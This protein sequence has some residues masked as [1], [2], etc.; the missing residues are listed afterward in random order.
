[1]KFLFFGGLFMKNN[2][3]HYKMYKAKKNIVYAGLMT[4]ATLAGLTLA[5][6]NNTEVHADV[7]NQPAVTATTS[8]ANAEVQQ[9]LLQVFHL[10]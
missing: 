2:Q 1:M 3:V 4:T 6:V 5:N 10:M 7:A 8:S 9:V